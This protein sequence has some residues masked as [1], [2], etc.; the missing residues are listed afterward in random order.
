MSK[1]CSIMQPTYLPWIGYFNLIYSSDFFVFLD[2]VQF[3]KQSW[4]NRN[5]ILI[6]KKIHWLTVPVIKKSLEDRINQIKIDDTQN[7]RK[8]HTQSIKQ[9]YFNHKYFND[10]EIILELINDKEMNYLLDL[11]ISIIKAIS[12]ALDIKS[13]KFLLSSK[14]NKT[15]SRSEKLLRIIKELNCDVYLSPEGSRNY[16]ERDLILNKSGIKIVY[17]N[18]KLKKYDQKNSINHISHLSVIDIIATIALK[19]CNTFIQG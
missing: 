15:G 4:Q 17:Q 19:N 2:D 7:W 5:K 16:I 12:S 1:I 14:L 18:F 10:L 13:S 8:K 6:K 11:N 3:S 9:N